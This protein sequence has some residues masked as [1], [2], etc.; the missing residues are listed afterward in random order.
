MATEID[1]HLRLCWDLA[2]RDR[3]SYSPNFKEFLDKIFIKRLDKC[4]GINWHVEDLAVDLEKL[5][6]AVDDIRYPKPHQPS[7][8]T[9]RVKN[10]ALESGAL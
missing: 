6:Q 5:A 3:D 8:H 1:S 7:E 9:Y 10:P 4:K 2:Q